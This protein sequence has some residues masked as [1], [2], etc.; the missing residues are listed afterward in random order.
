MKRQRREPS[1]TIPVPSHDGAG[2]PS[3]KLSSV[4]ARK[5]ILTPVQDRIFRIAQEKLMSNY[6]DKAWPGNNVQTFLST[7]KIAIN[8]M[9]W[10]RKSRKSAVFQ[11]WA[12]L[13]PRSK[14]T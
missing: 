1:I 3:H 4:N 10:W 7:G 8:W 13:E 9:L 12:P 5:Q 6:A 11:S 2:T 14:S